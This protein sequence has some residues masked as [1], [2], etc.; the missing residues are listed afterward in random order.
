MP[1]DMTMDGL[2]GPEARPGDEP[3]NV[4]DPVPPALPS[5]PPSSPPTPWDFTAPGRP[6]LPVP[7]RPDLG[8]EWP[9]PRRR[10]PLTVALATIV[11]VLV[12]VGGGVGLGSL[13]HRGNGGAP[14]DLS[15]ST[16]S[17][18]F[19]DTDGIVD[20]N[21]FTTRT[22][23]HEG[24]DFPLGAGT[25]MIITKSGQVLTNNH[26]IEGATRIEV[27]I[28]GG[29][30][31]QAQ[32]LGADPADDVALL[33]LEGAEN[34]Q[35]V[36]IADSSTVEVADRVVAIGNALGRGGAPS[37]SEGSVGALDQ[38]IEV[39]GVRGHIDELDGVIQVMTSVS[40]GDSGGPL[41]NE[42]GDV[43]GMITAADA[44]KGASPSTVAFAI[45]TNSAIDIVRRIRLGES[46]A[47]IVIG[48]AGY[49]GVRVANM[50]ASAG[51]SL[52]LTEGD[53]A[54]VQSVMPGSPA[55]DIGM[56]DN[57]VI[58]AIDGTSI[59]T[60]DDLGPAIH[61]HAPGERIQVTWIDTTG[62]HTA[63]AA[64][65]PGPAV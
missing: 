12:L 50:P 62:T 48:D 44:H 34:L 57:S 65:V 37:I 61:Q 47:A 56:G 36:T 25:G 28:P 45:P 38:S 51:D 20:V 60:A 32:V 54:Y 15:T 7:G 10:S 14:S 63:S 42:H 27:T 16:G 17:A 31:Y 41:E 11:A 33:Q 18:S 64:L 49:L 9:P 24:A 43:V 19:A 59:S 13:L 58:T 53:G 39:R 46:S 40:P 21:T 30:V 5:A 52:G 23:L 1:D 8:P 22:G 29:N 3:R 55:A 35:T 26:V 6:D 2:E 4:G